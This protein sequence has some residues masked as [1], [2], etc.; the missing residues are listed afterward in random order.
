[1]PKVTI[2]EE[3]ISGTASIRGTSCTPQYLL[4]SLIVHPAELGRS[5]TVLACVRF[6][7]SIWA[8]F[9]S[10]HSVEAVPQSQFAE[11]RVALEGENRCRLACAGVPPCRRAVLSTFQ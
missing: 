8:R 11:G 7:K 10:L 2:I 9:R 6:P 3:E 4:M 5:S 1:M